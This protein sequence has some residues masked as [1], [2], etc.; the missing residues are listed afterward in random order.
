M[1]PE[2]TIEQV[3]SLLGNATNP[4]SW[5][6][7]PGWG[8]QCHFPD[9]LG[10]LVPDEQKAG[11]MRLMEAAPQLARLL[12]AL[13]RQQQAEAWISVEERLPEVGQAVLVFWQGG[14]WL[15]SCARLN[16]WGSWVVEDVAGPIAAKTVTH[17][18]PLPE[19]PHALA[20]AGGTQP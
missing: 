5:Y 11:D 16:A 17:W 18:R 20:Q 19:P 15:I 10:L 1:F 3:E 13:M 9:G 6:W 12:L 7:Q 14:I 2:L 8:L 4:D